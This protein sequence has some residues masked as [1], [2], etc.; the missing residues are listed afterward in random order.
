VRKIPFEKIKTIFF[1]Y[2][3]T[4][5]NS[6]IIYGPAFRKAYAHLVSVGCAEEKAFSDEEISKWL[7]FN[8]PQMWDTFMPN[9]SEERKKEASSIIGEE[10]KRLTEQGEA[11]LYE[12]AVETLGALKDKGY[13]L[14]FLSNCKITY[15]DTHGRLFSLGDYFEALVCSEEYNFLPKHEILKQIKEGY[16]GDY[17]IIGDRL[18]DME[19]G[20]KNQV[21]TI[22]CKYG[23]AREGELDD[24]DL[25]ID[26]I[27]DLKNYF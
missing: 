5:H 4:I 25:L 10:M 16:P 15:R 9:L 24:A 21:Y 8:P 1:D 22:G 12:E 27:G 23:F 17:V 2:D 6:I 18:L 13:H 7:G 20:L 26:K 11:K 14:V 19:A 3:G